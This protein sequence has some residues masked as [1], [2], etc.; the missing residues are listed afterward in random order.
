MLRNLCFKKSVYVFLL[1]MLSACSSL[2]QNSLPVRNADFQI[3]PFWFNA[4]NPPDENFVARELNEKVSIH[5]YFD[6]DPL[7][8]ESTLRINFVPVTV[9]NSA[10]LYDFDMV[11]GKIYKAANL[12]KQKDPWGSYERS[13]EYPSVSLGIIPRVAN[14]TKELSPLKAIVFHPDD[15]NN[16]P[17][18]LATSEF[19]RIKLIGSFRLKECRAYPCRSTNSWK[20]EIFLV[21]VSTKNFQNAEIDNSNYSDLKRLRNTP[22]WQ[23]A[24]AF[25]HTQLGVFPLGKTEAYPRYSVVN[26]QGRSDTLKLLKN[27]V[28]FLTE[29]LILR[30][31]SNCRDKFST[32]YAKVTEL[33][34]KDR[35][36]EELKK[37]TIDF[38]S[39]DKEFLNSCL[40]IVRPATVNSSSDRLWFFAFLKAV[41]VLENEDFYFNCQQKTWY[42]NPR[43]ADSTLMYSTVKELEKCNPQ[44]AELI[45]ES[46]INGMSI[47]QN[48]TGR[49]YRFIEYD[50]QSGGSHQKMYSWLPYNTKRLQ[51]PKENLTLEDVFPADVEWIEFNEGK[52]KTIR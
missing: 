43:D 44:S 17:K 29:D 34:S 36:K 14:K 42:P 35:A 46:A 12:C 4:G 33:K 8:D 13:V 49:S 23:E 52:T 40:S 6:V 45:Y 51:C 25:L 47:M 2:K 48:Q 19:W 16:P 37:F 1:L 26:E 38:L 9:K 31:R 30:S 28:N 10:F 39:N 22:E 11:S 50:T 20:E 41:L 24:K 27:D 15:R 21:G 32:F 3:K 5:P 18:D 7:F